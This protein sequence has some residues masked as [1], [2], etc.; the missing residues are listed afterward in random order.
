MAQKNGSDNSPWM[1][2]GGEEVKLPGWGFVKPA[3]FTLSREWKREGVVNKLS[4][5]S[6]EEE[7]MNEGIGESEMEKPRYQN[8][9]DKEIKGVDSRDKVKHNEGSGWWRGWWR[10]PSK[11]D[12]G[13]R[14]STRDLTVRLKLGSGY[15]QAYEL[16]WARV[17]RYELRPTRLNWTP[18]KLINDE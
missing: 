1:Q 3:G 13:W 7:L 12:D 11:S 10:W 18:A 5:G 8:E 6:E 4:G 9:V 2:A 16:A 15:G 17:G 14:A